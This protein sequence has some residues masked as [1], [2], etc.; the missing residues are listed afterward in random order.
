MAKLTKAPVVAELGRPETPE[1]EAIRRDRARRDR[2]ARQTTFNLVIA[3]VASVL[4]AAYFGILMS[5]QGSPGIDPVHYAAV[6]A[7]AQPGVDTPL[8]VPELPDG[9]QANRAELQ[10]GRDGVT[11]WRINFLTP[12]HEFLALKQGIGANPSWL[13]DQLENTDQSGSTTVGRIDWILHEGPADGNLAH[14]MSATDGESALVLYG[15]A[16][17][18]AFATLAAAIDDAITD[19]ERNS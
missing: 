7:E 9:W 5:N 13:F 10:T 4:I 12:D 3:T 1:E 6:A 11:V 17:E 8:L 14:A 2:R 19:A 15:T 18:E 16:T